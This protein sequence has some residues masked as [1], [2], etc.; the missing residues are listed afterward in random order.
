MGGAD[1]LVQ[2]HTGALMLGGLGERLVNHY[3]FYAAF[4]S[5]DEYRLVAGSR[6]LGTLPVVTPVTEGMP[7]VF[8]GR[9]WRVTEVDDERKVI[10]LVPAGGGRPPLFGGAGATVHEV[11]RGEMR[12]VLEGDDVPPFLDPEA[13]A[14]L[15]EGRAEYR[16]LTLHERPFVVWDRGTLWFPWTG[17]RILGTLA[18]QFRAVGL[19]AGAESGVLRVAGQTPAEVLS[20]VRALA[21]AGPA[22]GRTL[23]AEVRTKQM[24][25]HH[26]WLSDALLEADYAAAR[27]D[28]DGALR[29]LRAAAGEPVPGA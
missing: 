19:D 21:A 4:T 11:V 25:K 6:T 12:E 22:D 3:D 14:L 15:A 9:R 29:V 5:P 26:R 16:T 2:V 24:E 23:A 28:T 18:L 20:V 1:L 8:A 17:D 7:L 13:R 10:S 27:L